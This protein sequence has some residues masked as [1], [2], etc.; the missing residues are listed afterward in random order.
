MVESL[1][2]LATVLALVMCIGMSAY[3]V[4]NTNS[5][6]LYFVSAGLG[7]F[8]LLLSL[9]LGLQG[10]LRS[11]SL[12]GCEQWNIRMSRKG[13]LVQIIL[14]CVGL[15]IYSASLLFIQ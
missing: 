8:G 12:I 7:L 10:V 14:L 4:S 15:F 13:F 2:V 1:L 11:L 5:G 3:V 6:V 9:M